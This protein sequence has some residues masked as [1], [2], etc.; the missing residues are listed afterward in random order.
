MPKNDETGHYRFDHSQIK[1]A[2]QWCQAETARLLRQGKTVITANTF[3]ELWEM[4]FYKEFAHNNGI[5]LN[6]TIADGNYKNVHN[7][8]DEVVQSQRERFEYN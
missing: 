5:A 4:D 1:I 7:V 2:H 3:C 6:I 8:P